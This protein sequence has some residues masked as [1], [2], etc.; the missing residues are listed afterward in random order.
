MASSLHRVCSFF[1][2]A[3]QLTWPFILKKSAE[4]HEP[5]EDVVTLYFTVSLLQV[6]IIHLTTD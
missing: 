4:N 1:G 3:E 5:L 6:Y 2:R